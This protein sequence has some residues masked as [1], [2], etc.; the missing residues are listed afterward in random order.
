MNKHKNILVDFD[1]KKPFYKYNYLT[2]CLQTALL[3]AFLGI[4]DGHSY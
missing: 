2:F 4:L 3:L 1:C